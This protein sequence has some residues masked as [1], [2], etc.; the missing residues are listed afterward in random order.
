[1]QRAD[2]RIERHTRALFNAR[3][4]RR[5]MF[6]LMTCSF[7]ALALS[8]AA[9]A[10]VYNDTVGDVTGTFSGFNHLDI[11]SVSVTNTASTLSFTF[12]VA[13]DLQATNWGKYTVAIDSHAGGD[14][15]SNGWGR[16]ISQPVGMDSWLG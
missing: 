9:M 5:D 3:A 4:G 10:T 6:K 16:P 8:S 2:T 13:G 11:Q 14:S 15:A 7:A 1:M 12:T